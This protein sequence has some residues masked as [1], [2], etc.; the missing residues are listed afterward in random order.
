MTDSQIL[1]SVSNLNISP[2]LRYQGREGW[3]PASYLKKSDIQSQKQSAGGA[4][5]A[6]TNDLDS[7]Q[8]QQN[9]AAKENRDNG[10]KENRLSFFSDKSKK[11]ISDPVNRF[12]AVSLLKLSIYN[13][14]ISYERMC[15]SI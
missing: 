11:W 1:G 14:K 12:T 7:K 13:L 8:N 2:A 6:S 10:H 4:V 9:N 3:A 5:H 15:K